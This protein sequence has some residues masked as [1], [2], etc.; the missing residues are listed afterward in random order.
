ML[1]ISEAV[2][3]LTVV[4]VGTSLP[5]LATSVV[6]AAR[7]EDDIAVGNIVGSNVFNIL[8]I[9]G[10][11]SLVSPLETT[12]IGVVDLASMTF[13]SLVL[14]PLAWSGHRLSRIEGA[15][16]LAGYC[17]YVVWRFQA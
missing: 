7:G 11:A 12:G 15:L 2:I 13:A 17:A 4:A 9:L 5:E 3:G 16:L 10:A 8:A 1:G 6:A 14:L